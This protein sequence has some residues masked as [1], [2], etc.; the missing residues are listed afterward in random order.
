[1]SLNGVFIQRTDTAGLLPQRTGRRQGDPKSGTELGAGNGQSRSVEARRT[2][3]RG[4]PRRRRARIRR[5]DDGQVED[6]QSGDAEM[7]TG[8]STTGS[9]DTTESRTRN[10]DLADTHAGR[11]CRRTSGV[12]LLKDQHDAGAREPQLDDGQPRR[13]APGHRTGRRQLVSASWSAPRSSARR[14]SGVPVRSSEPGADRTEAA[15]RGARQR[16]R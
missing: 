13:G 4:S 7:P 2:H 1:M 14:A 5:Q 3:E 16:Q 8:S 6:D 9:T 12:D 11:R 10:E 15:T